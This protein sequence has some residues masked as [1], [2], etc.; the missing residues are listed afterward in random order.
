MKTQTSNAAGLKHMSKAMQGLH[1][2]LL[3]FQVKQARFD[4]TPLELFETAT[5]S[6]AFEW[7]KPLRETIVAL[8]ERRAE[9]EPVTHEEAKAFGDRFRNLLDAETGPF[10]DRLNAAFQSDPDAIWAVNSARKSINALN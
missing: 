10:R 7:L 1:Q 2:H 5:K 4:G 9:D 8:D 3:R 6:R